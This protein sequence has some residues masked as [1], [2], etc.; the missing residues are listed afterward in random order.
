MGTDSAL[1]GGTAVTDTN[2]QVYGTENLH[3]V[4]ASIFPGHIVTNPSV[5]GH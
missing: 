4:D 3:V 1:K 2:T 5:S